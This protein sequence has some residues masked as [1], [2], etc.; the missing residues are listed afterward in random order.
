MGLRSGLGAGQSSSFTPISTNPFCMD[1]R[2]LAR[3]MKTSPRPSFL[4]R[5]TLQLALCIQA[6]R[7]LLASAK[8]RFVSQTARWCLVIHHSWESV[9]PLLQ[10]PMVASFTP[11]QPTLGIAHSAL[12]LL[13]GCSAMETHFMKLLTNNY[14]ADVAFRGSLEL[15]SQCCNRRQTIFTCY[16]LQHSAVPFCELVRPTTSRLNPCCS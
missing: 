15:G 11:L 16:A 9:F 6:G 3:T 2:D 8:P 7:V 4:I 1:L 14:C 5:K 12:R 10:S 13:C